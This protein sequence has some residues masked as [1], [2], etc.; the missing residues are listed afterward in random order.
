VELLLNLCWLLLIPI[1]FC[2]WLR[3]LRFRSLQAALALSCLLFLLFP[4]ISAT[5]D[6][7][8]M[9]QEL[10]ESSPGKR[11][12]TRAAD[13][14]FTAGGSNAPPAELSS[15]FQGL[16]CNQTCGCIVIARAGVPLTGCT[17][18]SPG[19]SPPFSLPG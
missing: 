4:I 19:R 1:A 14:S 16:P 13:H 9:R 11:T 6:L 17:T 18:I 2:F 7:N 10:E 15:I 3:Q 12:L 8:A 5:D